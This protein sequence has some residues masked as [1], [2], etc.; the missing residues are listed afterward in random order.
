[1]RLGNNSRYALPAKK[2]S[3]GPHMRAAI[4]AALILSILSLTGKNVSA[5]DCAALGCSGTVAYVF[6]PQRAFEMPKPSTFSLGAGTECVPGNDN[7]FGGTRLP[8]INTVQTIRNPTRL[9]D[10]RDIQE[11]LDEFQPERAERTSPNSCRVVWSQPEEGNGLGAGA[12]AGVR[13]LGYRTFVGHQT[14]KGT[15]RTVTFP[16]Q[17]L[18]AMVLVTKD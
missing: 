3:K 4:F 12:G 6:L 10:E 14:V 16:Q 9:V 11:H 2:A 13:I 17:L 18:F 5:E 7:P 15:V 1:M 8:A